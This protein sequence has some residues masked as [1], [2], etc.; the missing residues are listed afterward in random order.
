MRIPL[1]IS[2]A[3]VITKAITEKKN[4]MM[5][6][7]LEAGQMDLQPFLLKSTIINVKILPA[8]FAFPSPVVSL[9][10]APKTKFQTPKIRPILLRRMFTEQYLH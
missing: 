10:Q 8:D 4:A 2:I 7:R 9:P 5:L 1:T 6:M 3:V